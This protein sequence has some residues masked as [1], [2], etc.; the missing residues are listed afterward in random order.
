MSDNLNVLLVGAGYMAKEY[1][2]VLTAQAIKHIAVCRSRETAVR[3]KSETGIET[4]PGGIDNALSNL[5]YKL[6]K[7]IVA[8]S[9]DQLAETVIK[10]IEN[11]FVE[12]LVE[13]PAGINREQIQAV[14]HYA[15]KAHAKVF[16]AYNRRFYA[17]TDKAI[18]IITEDG[19]VSSYNFEFTEWS[20]IV[21]KTSHTSEI[22]EEWM[23]A[24]SSHVV[25]LAFFLGGMPV[26][27]C[28]YR[29]GSLP[30]HR[31]ASKYAGAGIT[32]TGV[33]FSYQANWG[34]P[35][36]WAV[37]V[38]TNEHRLFFRPMEKLFIQNI[39]SVK[40]DE[41]QLDDRLD[42]KFKPGLFNQVKAFMEK[43]PDSR[44]LTIDEQL[45][46]MNFYEQIEGLL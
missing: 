20:S 41:V 24:N 39:G 2:R 46:H 4:I 33:L 22:K 10:L 45:A 15:A 8:V 11:G 25:D 19:G 29:S 37:E 28:S 12:I 14:C 31:R 30:W 42:I 21:E 17:S 35:G 44:L 43:K 26:E 36:R 34:A 38:L 32:E 5:Q 7:S 40:I 23:L 6:K 27:M 9:V 3:F 13:K 16:V 1:S 18:Q